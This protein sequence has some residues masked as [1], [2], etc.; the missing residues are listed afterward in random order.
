MCKYSYTPC[1]GCVCLL[2]ASQRGMLSQVYE[3]FSRVTALK[4]EA[5]LLVLVL[6]LFL[7]F[8][9]RRNC[10]CSYAVFCNTS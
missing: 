9:Q 8:K 5:F 4:W 6:C 2:V 3:L 10:L 7:S 1:I